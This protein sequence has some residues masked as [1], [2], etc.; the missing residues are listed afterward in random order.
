VFSGVHSLSFPAFMSVKHLVVGCASSVL[1]VKWTSL[2][3]LV[4]AE[5]VYVLFVHHERTCR[6]LSFC[7]SG[8]KL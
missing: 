5:A 4:S 3:R 2:I 1:D 8:H 6:Q 7:L